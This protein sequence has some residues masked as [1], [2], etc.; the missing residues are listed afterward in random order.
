MMSDCLFCKIVNREIP[1]QIIYE[2]E[3]I[4]VFKDIHPVAP[5]HFLAIPKLHIDN[6]CDA[7]LG[8]AEGVL[9]NLVAAIQAIAKEQGLSERGFRVVVNYGPDAGEAVPHLHFHLIAGRHLNWP[10]G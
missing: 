10:P 4:L 1:S 6:I 7:R 8:T 3:Q 2:S 5:L 9:N